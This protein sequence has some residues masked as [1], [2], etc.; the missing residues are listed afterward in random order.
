MEGGGI[1]CLA[2]AKSIPDRE[3]SRPRSAETATAQSVRPF[4][5]EAWHETPDTSRQIA[6][7]V[8]ALDTKE[9]E[10]GLTSGS[11]QVAAHEGL[12]RWRPSTDALVPQL[13]RARA[14]LRGE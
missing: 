3:Y 13:S 2:L 7:R 8:L 12:N 6:H 4:S 1:H 14:P 10:I 5:D 9:I 11:S